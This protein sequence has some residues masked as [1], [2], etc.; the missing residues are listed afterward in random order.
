MTAEEVI[1]L[2][3]VGG[4]EGGVKDAGSAKQGIRHR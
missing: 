3:V 1:D 4:E 2:D